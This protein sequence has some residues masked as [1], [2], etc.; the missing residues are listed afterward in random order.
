MSL[1]V[2]NGP[3]IE[4]GESLSDGIDLSDGNLVRI[5]FPAGW[6]GSNLTFQ[7]SS[8]GN[9]YNDLFDAK[10]DEVTLPCRA[11]GA[12]VV[13]EGRW[14]RAINFLKIRSG[15]RE[16]PYP[17]PQRREFALAVEMP[18]SVGARGAGGKPSAR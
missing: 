4:S 18:A 10:G 3:V 15:T 7:I 5:T 9:G 17:Q 6:E 2:L 12:V 1:V 11:G 13:D 16:T 8:D 14:A